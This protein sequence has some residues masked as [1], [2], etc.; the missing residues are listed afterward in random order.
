MYA[1]V[2]LFISKV[3]LW[4]LSQSS[5]AL[6]VVLLSISFSPDFHALFPC[7][8]QKL[9]LPVLNPSSLQHEMYQTFYEPRNATP[10]CL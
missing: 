5:P 4:V 1:L 6:V 7:F 9:L 3:H 2:L 10:Y 8:D